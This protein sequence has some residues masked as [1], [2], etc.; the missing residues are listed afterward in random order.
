MF[1]IHEIFL[2]HHESL[3]DH[4][5]LRFPWI[6]FKP[7]KVLS[8]S[9]K[10][11]CA[12]N[13]TKSYSSIQANRNRSRASPI[14]R[15]SAES[16]ISLTHGCPRSRPSCEST[17]RQLEM[18]LLSSTTCTSTSKATYKQVLPQLTRAGKIQEWD[19]MTILNQ[20]TG[21]YDNPNKVQEAEDKLLT[22]KQGTD[23][24]PVYIAK[25]ER[26]LYE[27]RGQNW[28]DVNNISTFRNR[29]VPHSETALL[30]IGAINGLRSVKCARLISPAL[31]EQYRA[32][33][34]CV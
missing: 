11:R 29:L 27:A 17:A 28:P 9:C 31:H 24:V 6:R 7:S 13:A 23:T 2:K 5:R 25:F 8:T 26:V 32:E 10:S 33:G 19:Y 20:L 1:A 21:V 18:L 3:R 34:F 4:P 14:P 16:H 22:I 12:H 15:N 30:Q